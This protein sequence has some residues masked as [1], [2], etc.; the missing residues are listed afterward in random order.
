MLLKDLRLVSANW[1][2]SAVRSTAPGE[3]S[4]QQ[5]FAGL[6]ESRLM[7]REP[8]ATLDAIR[9]VW[10][11]LWSDRALLYRHELELDPGKS[12]M[13]VIIQEMVVGEVSGVL[14]TRAPQDRKVMM[15]EAV[16]GL[17][18]A[19]VDGTI[20]PDNWQLD[21]STGE[22]LERH[23]VQHKVAMRPVAHGL[24]LCPLDETEQRQS[25][26]N[27]SRCHSLYQVGCQLEELLGDAVDLEWTFAKDQ[28]YILQARP[29]T[30]TLTSRE[31]DERPWYL[32]LH[33]S[34]ENLE[35]LQRDLEKHVL[36]SMDS[37]A[38]QMI[39]IDLTSLE[40]DELAEEHERRSKRL[41]YWLQVYKDKC[42]PMAHGLRL[43]G[44][45]YNDIVK[46]DDP[47]EF[48]SLLHSGDLLAVQ[49][50][51]N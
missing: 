51:N 25:P 17:N 18:Q 41:K 15:V 44:E 3:D 48:V 13:A 45:F 14:F 35:E 8:E 46:P 20:E 24:E 11:S 7:L 19:L 47:F 1:T 10:A 28:L 34:L 50:T 6:H 26:L 21:R 33:R 32:S 36:P 29:I 22:V 39:M 43:F 38:K 49:R 40:N 16:W 27:E 37:D 5:S 31:D 9:T 23:E 12:S 42:V 2:A 30:A 4:G